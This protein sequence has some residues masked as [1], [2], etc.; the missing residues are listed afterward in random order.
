[1]VTDPTIMVRERSS[2][3]ELVVKSGEVELF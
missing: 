1:L 3:R 2:S